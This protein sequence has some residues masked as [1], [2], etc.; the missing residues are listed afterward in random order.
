MKRAICT[1][2]INSPTEAL[3]KFSKFTGWD[4]V[5]A[6]D[7]NS[8]PFNLQNST[9]L[10]IAD[11]EKIS[12]ELSVAIGFKTIQRRNF[13]HLWALR[14]GYETIAFVDDDNIPKPNWET[15][16]SKKSFTSVEYKV[17]SKIFDP[18]SVIV[19]C[20]SQKVPHRGVPISH[21]ALEN[22]GEEVLG[23]VS[24][25]PDVIAMLWDGDWD[26]NAVDRIHKSCAGSL[27]VKQSYFSKTISPFNSQN[28]VLTSKA[29]RDYFLLPFVG[30]FDDIIASY[31]LLAKGY[32]CVYTEPT[33][34]QDR[35]AHSLQK[36]IS[37]ELWGYHNIESI[38]SE[39]LIGKDLSD[40]SIIPSETKI[41]LDVWRKLIWKI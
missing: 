31:A 36:D 18:L 25:D 15:V 26:V 12:K 39:L 6:L 20:K 23:A 13:A 2:T 19:E 17:D 14:N 32:Q 41:A 7:I 5:V 34:R 35:N 16:A 10:T 29:A 9:I 33:V 38:V 37:N 30:R 28:T 21:Y 3:I 8:E 1:T 40:L 22:H 24:L 4:L 11:Q 27:S